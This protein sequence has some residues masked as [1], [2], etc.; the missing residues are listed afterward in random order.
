MVEVVSYLYYTVKQKLD[1]MKLMKL[2]AVFA[3]VL[4]CDG[5]TEILMYVPD[6]DEERRKKG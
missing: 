3:D 4:V 2:R 6:G 1:E 5:S